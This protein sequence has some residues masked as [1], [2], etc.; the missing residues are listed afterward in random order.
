MLQNHIFQIIFLKIFFRAYNFFIFV[1]TFQ[2]TSSEFFFNF[3]LSSRKSQNQKL[4]K[5]ITHFIIQFLSKKLT[6][7]MNLDS[8]KITCSRNTAKNLSDFTANFLANTFL[9]GVRNKHLHATISWRPKLHSWS[10]LKANA[11]IFL[12]I[13]VRNVLFQRHSKILSDRDGLGET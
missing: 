11:L 8:L 4:P 5:N 9:F 3:R 10:T 12:Y 2:R 13:S 6:H 1:H 7:F